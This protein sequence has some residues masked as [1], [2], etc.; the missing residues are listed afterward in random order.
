MWDIDFSTDSIFFD[1]SES[2]PS[3]RAASGTFNG[4]VFTDVSGTIPK[5]SNVTIDETV[6][7]LGL[8]SSD[9]TFTEDTIEVNLESLRFNT[10]TIAKLDVEFGGDNT[11]SGKISGIKWDDKNGD[12]I[13]NVVP[14]S[15][16]IVNTKDN[17]SG[18]TPDQI[19]VQLVPGNDL[20]FDVIV[21]VPTTSTSLPLDLVLLQDLSTSFSNDLNNIRESELI[22]DLVSSV[23]SI[24]PDTAFGITSFID[25]PL[26]DDSDI[27]VYKTD[28]PL[29]TNQDTFK[30]TFDELKIPGNDSDNSD[31][32]ESQLE[33]LM[34]LALRETEVGF[35]PNTRRV[36]LLTTDVNYNI[37]GDGSR[38]SITEANNG[39]NV[40]DGSPPGSGEDYPDIEQLK[41]ALIAANIVPIFAVTSNQINTY[42]DLV[43]QLGFGAVEELTSN[44]S[45]LVDVI[46]S[47]LDRA[48]QE[49]VMVAEGDDFSYVQNI[50]PTSYLDVPQGESRTFSVTLATDSTT[51]IPDNLTLKALGFGET[52]VNISTSLEPGLADVEIYLDL[53]NNGVLDTDE[54]T[55]ITATDDPNTTE[56]ETGYYEFINLSAGNYVVR[57]LIPEGYVQ[58]SPEEGFYDISLATNETV[59]NINFGN[60][61]DDNAGGSPLEVTI[62]APRNITANG[63]DEVTVTYRNTGDTEIAAPLLVPKE[64]PTYQPLTELATVSKVLVILPWLN[65]LMTISTFKSA[66]CKL[67]IM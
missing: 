57:E 6:T 20:S 2:A 11:N 60:Q 42:Q 63:T 4:Y 41:S 10:N 51:V 54:P 25:K 34:Q 48:F 40:L 16:S 47:G 13:R 43:N 18:F 58:T 55:T 27:Y 39:D 35:R 66:T 49:I 30:S 15:S 44:S 31:F 61:I 56:D 65:L 64:N 5:I 37:A 23:L 9:I 12:G 24:Q 29:T 32:P 67:I 52:E 22:P 19:D 14:E 26:K 45:N 8:D 46:S 21:T 33:A 28:L 3:T 36:V 62:S 50:T 7:T 53:N 59:T 1:F 17:P 38:K